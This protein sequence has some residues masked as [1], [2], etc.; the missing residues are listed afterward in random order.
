MLGEQGGLLGFVGAQEDAENLT[1]T[2]RNQR[3]P[4]MGPAMM[5]LAEEWLPRSR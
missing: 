1:A 3:V 4:F 5:G 2:G